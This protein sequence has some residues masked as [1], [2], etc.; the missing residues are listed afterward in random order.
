MAIQVMEFQVRVYKIR[1]VFTKK[2]TVVKRSYQILR[3]GVMA[4]CQKLGVI[5]EI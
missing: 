5:L 4:S 3:I 1:K 2:S